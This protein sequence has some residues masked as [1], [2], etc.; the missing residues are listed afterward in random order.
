MTISSIEMYYNAI[1]DHGIY[2]LSYLAADGSTIQSTLLNDYA[3]GW[4][5]VLDAGLI[6]G[7]P[8]LVGVRSLVFEVPHDHPAPNRSQSHVLLEASA[9]RMK[10]KERKRLR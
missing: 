5:D 7:G 4:H 1:P 2:R 9:N 10:R 8:P 3:L 6:N